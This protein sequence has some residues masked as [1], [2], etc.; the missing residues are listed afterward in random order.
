[1]REV[2]CDKCD[3]AHATGCCPH[4]RGLSRDDHKD[5]WARYGA[6]WAAADGGAADDG[7]DGTEVRGRAAVAHGVYS[8]A[9][10][11]YSSL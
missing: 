2:C 8:A 11:S 7:G 6:P 9:I 1:M 10:D 3:G 5:A 4:F